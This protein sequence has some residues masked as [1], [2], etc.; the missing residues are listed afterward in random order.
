MVGHLHGLIELEPAGP[1]QPGVDDHLHTV[2]VGVGEVDLPG[3]F[4]HMNSVGYEGEYVVE[5]EVVDAENT[6]QYLADAIAYL[7]TNCEV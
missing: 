3:L 4:A 6:L 2:V 1:R 5:M 7:R